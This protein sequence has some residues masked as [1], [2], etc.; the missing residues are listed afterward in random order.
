MSK[1]LVGAL[2]LSVRLDDDEHLLG[3]ERYY[4]GDSLR[5]RCFSID[6]GKLIDFR[7]VSSNFD[8]TLPV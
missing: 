5:E 4:L 2:L 1:L 8:Y 6:F 3:L 7:I